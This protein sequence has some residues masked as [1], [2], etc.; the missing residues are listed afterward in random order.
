MGA[1]LCLSNRFYDN[2]GE[3]ENLCNGFFMLFMLVFRRRIWNCDPC[4]FDG[5][6]DVWSS[7]VSFVLVAFVAIMIEL[8]LVFFMV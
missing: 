4:L 1:N 5:A 7:L 2:L 6:L 3:I 8:V